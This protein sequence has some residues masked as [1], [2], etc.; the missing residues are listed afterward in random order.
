M[1]FEPE[2]HEFHSDFHRT[3]QDPG[4]LLQDETAISSDG[5]EEELHEDMT[6][7]LNDHVALD[8]FKPRSSKDWDRFR[9]RIERLYIDLKL[10]PDDVRWRMEQEH[11]FSVTEKQLRDRLQAWNILRSRKHKETNTI[12]RK[13]RKRATQGHETIFRNANQIIESERVARF[14]RRQEMEHDDRGFCPPPNSPQLASEIPYNIPEIDEGAG[15]AWP[16]S[17]I[18]ASFSEI[19]NPMTKFKL[20]DMSSRPEILTDEDSGTSQ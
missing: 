7:P 3:P 14:E 8:L 13:H 18:D 10:R 5:S 16:L 19:L 17:D 12:S 11:H 6:S 15:S 1:S 20:N 4:V 9:S 2:H